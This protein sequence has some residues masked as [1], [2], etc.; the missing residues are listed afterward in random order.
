LLND[1]KYGHD[2]RD[3]VL[4]LSLLRSPTMPD[5]DA[6]QGEHRFAYSILPHSGGVGSETIAAAYALNDPLA[7]AESTHEGTSGNGSTA[8]T[9]FV[10]VDRDNVVIE[11]VKGAEDGRGVIVRMYESLRRQSTV[12]LTAGVPL[13]GAWRTNLLEHDNEELEVERHSVSLSLSPYEIATV[14]LI[15]AT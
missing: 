11:T 13:A 3:N 8:A 1:C 5:P 9:S 6:D 10:A 12:S 4:R 2:V 7:V 14:R 15:P